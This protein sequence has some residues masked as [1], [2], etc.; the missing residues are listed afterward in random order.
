MTILLVNP[1]ND[2]HANFFAFKLKNRGIPFIELGSFDSNDYSYENDKL[3]YNDTVI[4][5][6]TSAYIRGNFMYLPPT[7]ETPY[8]DTYNEQTRFKS[9]IE[10][11]HAW[12]KIG[13]QRGIHTLNSFVDYSK[14]LQLYRFIQAGLPVPKTC[15]TNSLKQVKAFAESVG[16]II[17]KPLSG[18][19][20]CKEFSTEMMLETQTLNGEPVIF[21]EYIQGE[22]IRVYILD[23]EFLSAHKIGKSNKNSSI[24][25]RTNTDFIKG[26]ANYTLIE[27]PENIKKICA[28][29]ASVSGLVFSGIDLKRTENDEFYLLECN[30]MPHYLDLE[31]KNEIKITD[32]LI[33]FLSKGVE[34]LN[35]DL[36]LEAKISTGLNPEA[37]SIFDYKEVYKKHYEDEKDRE[38]MIIL[39]LNEDQV[40]E[41][42]EGILDSDGTPFMVVTVKDKE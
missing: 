21:Q 38:G 31:F 11:L 42:E 30:S 32:K 37:D 24:D 6:I 18:G 27:L 1:M 2:F 23:G 10:M 36:F 8:I 33:D 14:H 20:Y 16:D 26:D 5:D 34:Y 12:I 17:F 9:Q 19:Y 29:A 22:D 4:E 25:Y 28:K 15:I 39:P 3:I 13:E 41:F 35:N 7:L 40:D